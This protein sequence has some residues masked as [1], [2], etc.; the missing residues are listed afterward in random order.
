MWVGG[1]VGEGGGKG[2]CLW[3]FRLIYDDVR[4]SIFRIAHEIYNSR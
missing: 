3:L 2:S 1:W 4:R